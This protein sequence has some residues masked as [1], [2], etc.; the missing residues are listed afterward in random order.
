[1]R[2]Y[3]DVWTTP[4][5]ANRMEIATRLEGIG[6]RTIY[7]RHDWYFDWSTEEEFK[8]KMHEVHVA[9]RGTA[10]LYKTHTITDA[11]A[12]DESGRVAEFMLPMR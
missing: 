7:G 6:L 12:E 4:D 10:A 2:T 5:G 3:V 1:M 8:G 9:L 11:D